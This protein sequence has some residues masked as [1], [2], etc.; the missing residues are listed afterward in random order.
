MVECELG[1][2]EG[3]TFYSCLWYDDPVREC[4]DHLVADREHVGLCLRADWEY[5]DECSSTLEYSI[6]K[7]SILHGIVDIDTAAEYRYCIS[8]TRERDI[9]GYRIDPVCSTTHDPTSSL[10]EIR[11]DIFEHFLPVTRVASRA[12]DPEHLAFLVEISSDVEEIGCL[13]DRAESL[14]IGI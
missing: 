7:P 11:Y 6:K 13:L 12:D 1:C 9:M 10:H 5:G 2:D 8:T 14:G 3:S 4:R